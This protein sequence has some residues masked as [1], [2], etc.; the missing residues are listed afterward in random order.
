MIMKY[1]NDIDVIDA[2]IEGY[3]SDINVIERVHI[4]RKFQVFFNEFVLDRA[5]SSLPSRSRFRWHQ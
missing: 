2:E 4:Q 3:D 1:D 5:S